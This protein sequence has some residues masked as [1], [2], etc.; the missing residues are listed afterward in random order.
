MTTGLARVRRWIDRIWRVAFVA[1]GRGTPQTSTVRVGPEEPA[2]ELARTCERLHGES[3][4]QIARQLRGVQSGTLS[5]QCH[6][7]SACLEGNRLATL[8]VLQTARP[9]LAGMAAPDDDDGRECIHAR[10]LEDHS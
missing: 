5:G 1:V 9:L 3:M 6:S 8:K 10:C 7:V 4:T 2:G